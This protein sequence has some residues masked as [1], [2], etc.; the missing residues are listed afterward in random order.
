M[1]APTV[2][3]CPERLVIGRKIRTSNDR[4]MIPGEGRI[5][6]TW[7]AFEE[8]GGVSAIPN[9]TDEGVAAGVYSDYDDGG[10][11][12]YALVIGAEVTSFDTIPDDH[13][14]IRLPAGRY[15]RF[16]V[17]GPVPT[18]IIET[19]GRIWNWF[20]SDTELER[21]FTTDYEVYPSKGAPVIYVAVR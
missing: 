9:T 16:D 10:N 2:E 1:E 18:G 8:A 4:E 7:E 12:E 3:D 11:G 13:V 14:A 17:D 19:W 20:E 15:A 6:P 5:A 21:A